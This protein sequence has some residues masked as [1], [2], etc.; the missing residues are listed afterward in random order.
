VS[1]I[2]HF[3]N[4]CW[5]ANFG[6]DSLACTLRPL[7]DNISEGKKLE[8]DGLALTHAVEEK[9]QMALPRR[10]DAKHLRG[11]RFDCSRTDAGLQFMR[12][13]AGLGPPQVPPRLRRDAAMTPTRLPATLCGF[14]VPTLVWVVAAWILLSVAPTSVA[15]NPA[16]P[17]TGQVEY[18]PRAANAQAAVTTPKKESLGPSTGEKARADAAELSDLADQLRDELH[19]TDINI[20]SLNIIQKTE[21][22]EKLTKKIKGE[23][24]GR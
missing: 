14:R 5:G 16:V 21:A 12:K 24:D 18:P 15:Q 22:I 20:L 9:M 1:G 13:P 19:R 7:A 11:T 6:P 4:D 17:N 3:R 8:T 2:S 10:N 23:A